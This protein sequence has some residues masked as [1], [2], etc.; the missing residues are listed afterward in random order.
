MF[1]QL[2][3]LKVEAYSTLNEGDEDKNAEAKLVERMAAT[4]LPPPSDSL[5]APAALYLT[6]IMEYVH[7][8]C[9]IT[10]NH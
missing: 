3:R 9:R 1:P 2:L 5:L 10:S 7:L 4:G 6:A 8:F